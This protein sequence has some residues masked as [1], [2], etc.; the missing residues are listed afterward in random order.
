[1]A[2]I[3]TTNGFRTVTLKDLLPEEGIAEV[4]AVY[5]RGEFTAAN[6]KPVLAKYEA[7]LVAKGVDPAYLAYALE[8][9][10]VNAGRS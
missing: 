6:L 7:A 1:M 9:A 5:N 3:D 8:Y 4:L 2:L 10:L